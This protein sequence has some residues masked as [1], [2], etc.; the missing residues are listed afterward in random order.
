[1]AGASAGLA[2]F[3]NRITKPKAQEGAPDAESEPSPDQETNTCLSRLID[4]G[5]RRQ[6]R[7]NWISGKILG[8]AAFVTAAR[9]GANATLENGVRRSG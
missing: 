4:L 3:P 6:N 8:K 5:V 1:M 2:P 7:G 9:A